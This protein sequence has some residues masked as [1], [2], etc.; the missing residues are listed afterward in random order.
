[1]T[2]AYNWK[3]LTCEHEVSTGGITNIHWECVAID[4]EYNA[5]VYGAESLTPDPSSPTFVP[6]DNVTETQALAWLW[7]SLDKTSIEDKLSAIIQSKKNPIT[8]TGTPWS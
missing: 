3:I 2:I 8:Q 6:Y 5:R 4:G 7:S 1:M